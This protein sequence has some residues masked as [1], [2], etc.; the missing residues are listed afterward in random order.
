[1]E[2]DGHVV[3]IAGDAAVFFDEL[4]EPRTEGQQLIRALDPDEVWLA[5]QHEPWRPQVEEQK[6]LSSER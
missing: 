1:V 5:H 6:G 4:D 3:V 2:S